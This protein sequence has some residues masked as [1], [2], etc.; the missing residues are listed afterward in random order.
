VL[1]LDG[2]VSSTSTTVTT[3]PAGIP[4]TSDGR[5]CSYFESNGTLNLC[6][7]GS[8]YCTNAPGPF[9]E[10]DEVEKATFYCTSQ[11]STD[12]LQTTPPSP[13]GSCTPTSTY[14]YTGLVDDGRAWKV[15]D[16]QQDQNT[17]TGPASVTF[18]STTSTSVS[19]SASVE[20]KV[21]VSALL[22]VIFASVR[23]DINASVAQSATTVVGNSFN[24]SVPAGLTAYGI[25]G[26]QEQ[27]ASGHLSGDTSCGGHKADYGTVKSYVPISPGWCVWLSD[28]PP[29]VVVP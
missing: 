4:C 27:V 14:A 3:T 17:T 26:V 8:T 2:C 20:V 11:T 21:D 10:Y 23:A 22:P 18:I 28:Q 9:Y 6:V 19:A 25:Y 16:K 1:M 5:I 15:V 13:P 7:I 29:C 12:C 24:L